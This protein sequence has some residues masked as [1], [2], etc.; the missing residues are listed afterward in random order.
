MS[1][2]SPKAECFG[3]QVAGALLK[4]RGWRVIVI[5]L[6]AAKLSITAEP[7]AFARG[8]FLL[9]GHD[10]YAA[11]RSEVDRAVLLAAHA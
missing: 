11:S 5:A 7:T 1:V 3:I 9:M 8:G 10:C 4:E 2:C 6:L